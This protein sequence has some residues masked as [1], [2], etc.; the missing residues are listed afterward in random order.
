MQCTVYVL[1][2]DGC[3]FDEEFEHQHQRD[4]YIKR[5]N[6]TTY[7]DKDGCESDRCSACT[8]KAKEKGPSVVT[9]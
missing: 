9:R 6:W 8:K 3:G 7:T 1:N 5:N 4:A 2:C